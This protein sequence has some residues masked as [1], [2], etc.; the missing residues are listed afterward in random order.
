MKIQTTINDDYEAELV[1]EFEQ[2][3]LDVAKQKAARQIAKKIKVAGFRPGK[4]PYNV[5]IKQVGEAAVVEEALDL[6]IDEYYPKIIE[7]ANI[8]PYGPGA[9]KNVPSL[10]PPTLEISV[11]LSPKVEINDYKAVRVP[12]EPKD[13]SEDD[14]NKSLENYRD[15]QAI[16]EPVER[17]VKEGDMVNI[18]LSAIR[19]EPKDDESENLIEERSV[20]I[21]VEKKDTKA[22]DEWPYPGYSRKLIGKNIGDK[23]TNK[24]TFPKKYAQEDLREVK[25][26]FSTEIKEVKGRSLPELNDAFAKSA[27]DFDTLEELT[28]SISDTLKNK[29]EAEINAE[30]DNKVIDSILENTSFKITAS[31]IEHEVEHQIQDLTRNLQSQGMDF[32]VYLKSSELDLDGFKDDIRPT[33]TDHLKRGLILSEIAKSENLEVDQAEIEKRTTE[34]IDNLRNVLSPEDAKKMLSKEY[35]QNLS[36]NIISDE[37]TNQTLALLRSIAK[38]EYK[39]DQPKS[40][41]KP[42]PKTVKKNKKQD[43][44]KEQTESKSHVDSPEETDKE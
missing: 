11:P 18:V 33:A 14:I 25:A 16:I 15:Q 31:M 6:V 44:E 32:D 40:K 9:L 21:I 24:Y 28:N 7:Q 5:V 8:D 26:Q 3:I 36:R 30:Y 17:A 1:V 22:D 29:F 38:G 41:T 20:P 27:G 39:A 2:E 43:E 37:I 4:A 19:V 23:F 13:V 42:K 10:E 35:I 34:M 12:F